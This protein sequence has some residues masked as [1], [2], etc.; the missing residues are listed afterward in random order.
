MPVR[1]FV[2]PVKAMLICLASISVYAH[3]DSYHEHGA[4]V[5]GRVYMAIAAAD[6]ELVIGWHVPAGDIFGFEHAPESAA[7]RE[8]IEKELAWLNSAAWVR[9]NG[10]DSCEK[11]QAD[12]QTDLLDPEHSGHGDVEVSFHW[13]C[14][15]PVNLNGMSLH[16]FERYSALESVHFDWLENHAA[17]SG[18]LEAPHQQLRR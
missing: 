2:I 4:H 6:N 10:S 8:A 14:S 5:H 16:L 12:A 1:S 3:D 18:T 11:V 17:G 15:A 13:Q 9:F 7:Q